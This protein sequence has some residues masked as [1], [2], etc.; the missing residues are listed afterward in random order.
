[1]AEITKIWLNFVKVMPKILSNGEYRIPLCSLVLTQYQSVTDGQTDGHA[2]ATTAACKASFAAC[3]NKIEALCVHI[4]CL[5]VEK[6]REELQH[7][8]A[9]EMERL[10]DA[11]VRLKEEY[12][13]KMELER[14]LSSFLPYF[15]YT[16]TLS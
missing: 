2:V 6:H 3:C 8:H 5:Q 16:Y 14:L 1:M 12:E 11:S 15:S 10:R 9:R 4:L 13:H 7:K